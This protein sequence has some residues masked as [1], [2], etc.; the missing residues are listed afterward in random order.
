M[1]HKTNA[2]KS[3]R[4]FGQSLLAGAALVLPFLAMQL[5]NRRTYAEEFPVVLF[6]FM[7]ANTVMIALLVIPVVQRVWV[8]KSTK[9]LGGLHWIGLLLGVGLLWVYGQ[10]LLDQMPCFVGL[11]NC[12]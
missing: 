2:G 11:L 8:H 9:A 10:V 3:I 12:D 4:L 1:T 5:V 6:A 7:L